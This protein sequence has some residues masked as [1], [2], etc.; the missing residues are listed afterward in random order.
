[1]IWKILNLLNLIAIILVIVFSQ[2][3]ANYLNEWKEYLNNQEELTDTRVILR[4]IINKWEGIALSFTLMFVFFIRQ[5]LSTASGI[6]EK[7]SNK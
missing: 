1:M 3:I 4:V 5:L 2:D 7:I 6:I